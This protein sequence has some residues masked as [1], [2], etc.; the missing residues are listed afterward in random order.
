MSWKSKATAT[1]AA[2]GS[3]GNRSRDPA[4]ACGPLSAPPRAMTDRWTRGGRR[5]RFCAWPT[6]AS[7]P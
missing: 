5:V 6:P 7:L 2:L 1:R 3:R 4:V